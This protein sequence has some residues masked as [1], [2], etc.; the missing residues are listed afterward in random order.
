[1]SS[2]RLLPP[3][4]GVPGIFSAETDKINALSF[5]PAFAL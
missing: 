3:N 1:M 2:S 4:H 5:G